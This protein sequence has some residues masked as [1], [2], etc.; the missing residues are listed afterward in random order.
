MINFTERCDKCNR[1]VR[2]Q[3]YSQVRKTPDYNETV[4]RIVYEL[5]DSD[6][7]EYEPVLDKEVIL[8]ENCSMEFT[9]MMAA[10]MGE[11]K[12]GKK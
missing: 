11:V 5:I 7:S 6:Q 1:L 10:F 8:C 3:N 9:K 4:S 2:S 12:D